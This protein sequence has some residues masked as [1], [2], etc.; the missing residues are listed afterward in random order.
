M[1]QLQAQKKL[2]NLAAA[3]AL[4]AVV[5][6][7]LFLVMYGLIAT[8]A[9]ELDESVR[10]RFDPVMVPPPKPETQRI[11]PPE[12]LPDPQPAPDYQTTEV[13]LHPE[14]GETLSFRNDGPTLDDEGI[15]GK[16][17]DS[18]IVPIFRVQ[19]EYP[20]RAITRGIE[21]YVDLLFD[22][23]AS[24]KTENIRVIAAEPEGYFERAAIRAL[25]KWKYKPPSDDGVPHGQEN[26][27]T[28]IS[29]TLDS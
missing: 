18:G 20:I 10:V 11:T 27:M 21:G 13:K 19:P 26:M 1:S 3:A 28:R 8:D 22:V 17:G 9:P 6:S 12:P 29:F 5:S 25:K 4:A 24:G 15:D 7:A 16:L 2:W 14:E 23:T